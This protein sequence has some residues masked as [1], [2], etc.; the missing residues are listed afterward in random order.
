M[1]YKELPISKIKNAILDIFPKAN[2][3]DFH[4][5]PDDIHFIALSSGVQ[6]KWK[7]I[8]WWSDFLLDNYNDSF[9]TELLLTGIESND[10]IL[11]ITD[12]GYAEN[13]GF[14]F[15]YKNFD[16]F[17]SKYEEKY[18]MEFY[19]DSDYIFIIPNKKQISILGH[20]GRYVIV[21]HVL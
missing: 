9:F 3:A 15:V 6:M 14:L 10:E 17:R 19:Q 7:E 4:L 20:E 11:L 21:K 13:I 12:E 8:S 18:K 16:V 5:T 1:I 2:Q